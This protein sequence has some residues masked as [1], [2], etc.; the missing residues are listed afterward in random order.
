MTRGRIHPRPESLVRDAGMAS[1]ATFA[2]W[3]RWGLVGFGVITALPLTSSYTPGALG[4]GMVFVALV[5]ALLAIPGPSPDPLGVGRRVGWVAV[6][7]ATWVV[8]SVLWG[9]GNPLLSALTATLAVLCGLVPWRALRALPATQRLG[10]F[11]WLC[12][13]GSVGS[14]IAAFPMTWTAHPRLVVIRPGLPIGGASN[15]GVG[16]LLLA[17][18][19]LLLARADRRRRP[20]WLALAI[21]DLL[22]VLQSVGRV[23]WAMALVVVVYLMVRRRWSRRAAVGVV[24]ASVAVGAVLQHDVRG[25]KAF[26]DRSRPLAARRALHS[27]IESPETIIVG[28]GGG[29]TWHWMDTEV[30]WREHALP[31]TFQQPSRWGDLLYHAHSTPLALLVERGLVGLGLFGVVTWAVA[32]A[33]ITVVRRADELHVV[34]VILL[35]S[36]PAMLVELYLLRSFPSAVLWWA[37]VWLIL[38]RPRLERHHA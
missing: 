4:Y 8:V 13:A 19:V 23:A 9:G 14:L 2:P 6:L 27:W 24:A 36:L 7:L 35:L 1:W 28:R 10:F 30:A 21:A 5:L 33:A 29:G 37:A 3:T 26:V 25:A 17:A 15:N 18:G 31:G 34:A 38:A 22:M 32:R 12:A 11:G 20:L 16:L